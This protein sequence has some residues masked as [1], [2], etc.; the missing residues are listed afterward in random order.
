MKTFTYACIA[1]A[2]ISFAVHCWVRP[3]IAQSP[4]VIAA[5]AG[6]NTGG[7]IIAMTENGDSIFSPD[8]GQHWYKYA[9]CFTGA[10]TPAEQHTWG[11]VKARY[12]SP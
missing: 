7:G 5:V 12:K 4:G 11:T 8:Y 1:V 3:A 10:P 9:N 6:A 2:A